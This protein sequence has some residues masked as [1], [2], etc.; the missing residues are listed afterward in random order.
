MD[1]LEGLR[2]QLDELTSTAKSRAQTASEVG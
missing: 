2:H 1:Q